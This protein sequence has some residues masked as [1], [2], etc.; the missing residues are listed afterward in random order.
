M[1]QASVGAE[2]WEFHAS[3]YL[4]LLSSK[5]RNEPD[6]RICSIEIV[7]GEA[8]P[9]AG[10]LKAVIVPHTLWSDAKRAPWLTTLS[11]NGIE[12]CPYDFIPGRPPEH[13]HVLL[14]TFVRDLYRSWGLM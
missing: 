6:D 10:S 4:N 1:V 2:P 7:L 3:A 13:Y 14:E 12:I 9:L 8:V 11:A 5:G